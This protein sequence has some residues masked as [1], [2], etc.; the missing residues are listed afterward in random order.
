MQADGG[1]PAVAQKP[2]LACS[3]TSG[4]DSSQIPLVRYSFR[5]Q[6]YAVTNFK[7]LNQN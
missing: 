3:V 1:A 6:E 4:L 2:T 5:L 7:S